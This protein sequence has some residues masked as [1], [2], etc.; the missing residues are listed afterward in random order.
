MGTQQLMTSQHCYH[1]RGLPLSMYA[2][3][4]GG[5][6]GLLYISIAY[7]MQKGGGWVQ[8]ACNIAYVLNGRPLSDGAV[9]MLFYVGNLSVS[10]HKWQL[11]KGD[12]RSPVF[13]ITTFFCYNFQK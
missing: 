5:G 1:L 8:I 7:Y 2:P 12:H 3:R 13:L 6:S 10:K 4:G 11:N 9:V